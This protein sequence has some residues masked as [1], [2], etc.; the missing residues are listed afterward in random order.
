MPVKY[1]N[2]QIDT[3]SVQANDSFYLKFKNNS[4]DILSV[5]GSISPV[6]FT[7]ED[8]PLTD[9]LLER[10]TFLIGANDLMDL[11]EFGNIPALVK[12]VEFQANP[13]TPAI[14]GSANLKTNGDT[15]LISSNVAAQAVKINGITKSLIYGTWDFTETYNGNAPII[16]DKDLKIIIQDDLSGMDYFRVSCHGIILH[17]N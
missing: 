14:N 10:V 4:S 9:L 17:D 11:S 7:L 12:G 13:G 3:N 5:D 8:L 16:L 6:E 15:M 1:N 2:L